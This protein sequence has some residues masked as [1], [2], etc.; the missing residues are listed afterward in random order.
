M[1]LVYQKT[2]LI[3]DYLKAAHVTKYNYLIEENDWVIAHVPKLHDWSV[4]ALFWTAK[5]RRGKKTFE[6]QVWNSVCSRNFKAAR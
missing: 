4:S 5:M 1:L 3:F 6:E 2:M